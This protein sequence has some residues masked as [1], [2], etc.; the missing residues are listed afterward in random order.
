[1]KGPV[2]KC[3]GLEVKALPPGSPT[4]TPTVHSPYSEVRR[5]AGRRLIGH[6]GSSSFLV[7]GLAL[8][9]NRMKSGV[10]KEKK[11]QQPFCP[12]NELGW[13]RP[14]P[15]P[16]RG[17]SFSLPK[18]TLPGSQPRSKGPLPTALGQASPDFLF[19]ELRGNSPNVSCSCP[20]P[21]AGLGVRVANTLPRFQKCWQSVSRRR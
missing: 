16:W 18:W 4:A 14:W 10:G 20:P 15:N 5:V 1:M 6:S 7:P 9:R 2:A 17:C 21:G 13:K 11:K 8:N 19:H 3:L 12:S